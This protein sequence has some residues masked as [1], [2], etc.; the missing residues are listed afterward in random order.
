MQ[1]F[2][3]RLNEVMLHFN[4]SQTDV[5]QITGVK[6]ATV[7]RWL[8]RSDITP[9]VKRKLIS[10]KNVYN[11]SIAYLETGTGPMI[12]KEPSN[13][14]TYASGNY[15]SGSTLNDEH[16]TGME[17]SE[18]DL[19][20]EIGPNKTIKRFK[21]IGDSMDRTLKDGD[22][23]YCTN[24]PF[25]KETEGYIFVL[26]TKNRGTII[27]RLSRGTRHYFVARS[28]NAKYSTFPIQDDDIRALWMV[29]GLFTRN[30]SES[31]R[32]DVNLKLHE[33]LIR[34]RDR[35]EKLEK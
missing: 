14:E 11:V 20:R 25:D 34:L 10:L 3:D 33:E 26:E 7:S 23:V 35:I 28:D 21:V 27:K 4:M 30:L 31:R 29:K 17:V 2:S 22:I 18:T 24:D 16:D 6:Q 15:E 9:A 12:M 32:E 1:N 13:P 19:K 5:A 8:Q